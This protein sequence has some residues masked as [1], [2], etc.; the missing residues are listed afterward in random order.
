ML[1]APVSELNHIAEVVASVGSWLSHF[2]RVG[3][4]SLEPIDLGALI[5]DTLRRVEN[6]RPAHVRTRELKLEGVLTPVRADRTLISILVENLVE[7]AYDALQEVAAGEVALRVRTEGDSCVIRIWD[8]G[9]PIAPES[10]PKIW[11]PGWSTKSG[12]PGYSRGLGLT[13]CRQ[14][15]AA[16]EGT[17]TLEDDLPVGGV[18]FVIRLP[19]T[20]PRIGLQE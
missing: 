11:E 20:G 13:L 15:V 2:V 16:H 3:T 8:N 18:G 5:P 17:L 10:R 12:L 19:L 4:I 6:R 9:P 7:N 14:I 1:Q